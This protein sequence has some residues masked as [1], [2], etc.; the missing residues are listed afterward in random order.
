MA[1]PKAPSSGIPARPRLVRSRE[2]F[3]IGGVCGGLAEH[4]GWRP[5][6]MRLLFVLSCVLPG[7]QILA[8]LI[9]WYVIPNA[10][11]RG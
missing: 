2:H 9:L 6:T 7:P 3:V 1:Q 11:K 10:P 5:Y 8:Y 4:F